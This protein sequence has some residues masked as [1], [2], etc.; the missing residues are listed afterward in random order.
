M[1][2][3]ALSTPVRRGLRGPYR[4]GVLILIV[5]TITIFKGAMTTSTDSGLA[6]PDW[7]WSDG[8]F[9]PKRSYTELPAFFEH[10]HRLFAA[11]AGLLALW[12]ALWL[13]FGRLGDRCS[14][15]TAWFGGCLLLAQAIIGGVGVLEGLPTATSVTHGTLAQLTLAT[16]AW[17]TYQL[18]ERSARTPFVTSVPTGAGR[19]L[20]IAAIVILVVQTVIGALASHTN[21]THALWTHVGNAFVVFVVVAIATAFAV[22]RIGASPG[23]KGLARAIVLLL[24]VQ[25]G[26]GF[27]ALLVRNAAGKTPENIANLGTAAL[28]SVHV[29]FGAVLTMMAALLAAHVFRATRAPDAAA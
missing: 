7:P 18:S 3:P 19:K 22:G 20:A 28:I 11:T 13:Q 2:S 15:A 1:S 25:I 23:I 5:A 9:M 24:I 29:L 4:L 26:L 10:F 12:L 8:E 27:V 6:F 17:L 21:N 14:R 16:F